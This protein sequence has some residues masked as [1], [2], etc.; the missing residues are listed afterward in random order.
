MNTIWKTTTIC[1]AVALSACVANPVYR[2]P[3]APAPVCAGKAQCAAEWNEARTFVINNA[4]YK[5]ETYSRDFL[6]TYNSVDEST[7]LDATVNKQPL[8]GGRFKIAASF[9]CDNSLGCFPDPRATLNAF[10]KAVAAAGVQ[11]TSPAAA[12]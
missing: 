5:I 7:A 1:A 2:G 10:N 11:D 4:G 8:P 3:I 12:K 9:G 6:Q